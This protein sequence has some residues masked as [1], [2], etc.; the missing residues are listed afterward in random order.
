MKTI[1]LLV[2]VTLS[3]FCSGFSNEK[4]WVIDSESRLS[5]RGA[6]NVNTFICKLNSYT[7]HDT[8][9]YFTNY[10]ASRLEF[11]TNSMTI[12]VRNFNCGARQI[13]KDFYKT[14]KS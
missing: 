14:L 12:P 5:I 13:S 2:V 10:T 6:T 8:L 1:R 7:G 9:R 4:T 3:L 11:T